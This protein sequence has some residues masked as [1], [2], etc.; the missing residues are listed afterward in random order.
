MSVI[1]KLRVEP[2]TTIS[3]D[4]RIEIPKK[5]KIS[6]SETRTNYSGRIKAQQII[7]HASTNY[8]PG[9]ISFE[10]TVES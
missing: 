9:K 8:I 4:I 6:P 1:T 5:G 10:K 7:L 3:E 2:E